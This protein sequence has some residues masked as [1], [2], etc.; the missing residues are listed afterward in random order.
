MAAASRILPDLEIDRIN[1]L[2]S[3]K[4]IDKCILNLSLLISTCT[5]VLWV[6]LTLKN[7]PRSRVPDREEDVKRE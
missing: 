4:G 1:Q 2:V 3:V 6:G 5:V 7:E